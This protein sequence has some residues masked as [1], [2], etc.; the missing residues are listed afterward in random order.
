MK[1]LI[2][3]AI[4]DDHNLIREAIISMLETEKVIKIL[5]DVSNGREL[6]D[7]IVDKKPQI[8]I[9]DIEMPILSGEE[10]L[11]IIRQR[12]PKIKVILLSSHF[13]RDVIIKFLKMGA[14]A[15]LPKDCNRAKLI[16]AIFSVNEEGHYFDKEVSAL[17]AKEL[18]STS[19]STQETSIKF[20]EIE[21]AIIKMICQNKINKEISEAL[22]LSTRTVEW[23]RL[24]IMSSLNSKD[25]KDLIMYAIKHKLITVV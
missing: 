20:K 15:F 7:K 4:A 16:E 19:S 1:D 11:R 25:V 21:L 23:H 10:A 9:L 18:A 8:I 24:N 6:I 22:N 3:I 14:S 2:E 17:M 5:F 13:Q 12:H